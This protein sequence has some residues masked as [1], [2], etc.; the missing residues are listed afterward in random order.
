MNTMLHEF[1]HGVYD[2]YIDQSLPYVLREPAH[3]FTTEAIAML[4]GRF[5]NN[6]QWLQ[7]MIGISDEEKQEITE[8]CFKTL[9]TEQLVFSRWVQVMYRFEKAMY[10]DPEQDLNTLWWD[11]VEKYQ[12]IK[13]PVDRNEPD[14]ATKIHIATSPCY[15]HNYLLGELLASQLL[16]HIADTIIHSTDVRL[17]SFANKKEVGAFLI[18]K[19][20]KP[21]SV[22]HWSELIKRATGEPLSARYYAKQ[23]VD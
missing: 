3:I 1:G 10:E 2:K 4:F 17:E 14:W 23:F 20:F 16:Y 13:R 18:D 21:G 6:P 7:D 8:N 22:Y 12:M 15:Y 11:L 19:I 9:R 5:S